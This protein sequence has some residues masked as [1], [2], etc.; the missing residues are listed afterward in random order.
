MEHYENIVGECGFRLLCLASALAAS[1]SA[2]IY[3]ALT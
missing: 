1:F 3:L 2:I